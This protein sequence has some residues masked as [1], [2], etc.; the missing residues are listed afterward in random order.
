MELN[1]KA[2]SLSQQLSDEILGKIKWSFMQTIEKDKFKDE[3]IS[4]QKEIKDANMRLFTTE[5]KLKKAESK[6]KK[7]EIKL[8]ET[9]EK[10]NRE[11]SLK[12]DEIKDLKEHLQRTNEKLY[13]K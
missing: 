8:V 11:F 3:F 12:V 1:R 2:T 4:A 5:N 13:N 6:I 10:H 7:R 9:N